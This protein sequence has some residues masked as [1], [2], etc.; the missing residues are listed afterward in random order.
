[1]IKLKDIDD[2][3]F[4]R[5]METMARTGVTKRDQRNILFQ[6][7]HIVKIKGECFLAHYK[8]INNDPLR[9]HDL[10]RLNCIARLIEKWELGKIDETELEKIEQ[11]GYT[12]TVFIL[13]KE[14]KERDNWIIHSVI[15]TEKL[16]N[17]IR[18]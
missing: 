11:E 10:K 18:S 2:V 16:K 3:N 17:F 14:R 6:I 4:R 8:E 9:E 7:A 12:D 13:S 15:T 5:I 1:M